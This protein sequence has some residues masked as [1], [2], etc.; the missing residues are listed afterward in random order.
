V[1]V[2]PQFAKALRTILKKAKLKGEWEKVLN[3]LLEI[4]GDGEGNAPEVTSGPA[5]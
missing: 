5:A 4:D 2:F 3:R 1:T